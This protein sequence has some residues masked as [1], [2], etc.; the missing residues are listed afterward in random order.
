MQLGD[1]FDADQV[2][3]PLAPQVR[4]DAEIGAA[5]DQ[6][7]VGIWPQ[8]RDAFRRASTGREKPSTVDALERRRRPLEAI[9]EAARRRADRRQRRIANRAIAGAAA[10]IA[11]HRQRIAWPLPVAPVLLG[12]QAHDE[13]RRAVAALRSAGGRHRLLHVGQLRRARRATSTV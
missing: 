4:L 5:G 1:R 11:G 7:G 10:Q 8:H 13:A 6:R 12:E 9:A 2:R 3:P